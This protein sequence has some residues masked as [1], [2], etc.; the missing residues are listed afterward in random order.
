MSVTPEDVAAYAPDAPTVTVPQIEQ[1]QDWVDAAFERAARPKPTEG[2]AARALTRAVM[3]YALHLAVSS[4][5]S[6]TRLQSVGLTAERKKIGELEVERRYDT[7]FTSV[8]AVTTADEY[9]A[10]AVQALREAGLPFRPMP[11]ASA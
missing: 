10:R 5:G 1:A 11:G 8:A 4:R 3:T 2:R 6:V 9:L 7:G